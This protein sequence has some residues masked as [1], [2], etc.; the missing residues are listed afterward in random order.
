MK[1]SV[2]EIAALLQLTL[3]KIWLVDY[4]IGTI[5]IIRH[6]LML[7]VRSIEK[8]A[9]S[10]FYALLWIQF[11]RSEN[12]NKIPVFVTLLVQGRDHDQGNFYFL[13]IHILLRACLR[14]FKYI[15]IMTEIVALWQHMG[16]ECSS[17]IYVLMC[18]E[19]ERGGGEPCMGIWNL[20]A[21]SQR[22]TFCNRASPCN[23]CN[24]F[25]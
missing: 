8:E 16:L 7:V 25:K 5:I 3:N 11:L 9:L 18:R 10:F 21:Y 1:V 14:R 6:L 17:E 2:G 15:F 19:K 4:L 22:H 20:K 24:P 12:I 23:Y 13:K